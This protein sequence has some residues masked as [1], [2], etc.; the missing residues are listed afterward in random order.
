[1]QSDKFMNLGQFSKLIGFLYSATQF[2]SD[3]GFNML[4]QQ[5]QRIEYFGMK[6]E[7]IVAICLT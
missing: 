1:M 6:T 2:L 3:Y 7:P 4:V 5:Y